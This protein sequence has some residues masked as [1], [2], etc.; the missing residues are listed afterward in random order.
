MYKVLFAIIAAATTAFAA[1]APAAAN[2]VDV[3][4]IHR[5]N[6]IH[7]RDGSRADMQTPPCWVKRSWGYDYSGKPYLKKTRVCA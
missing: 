2:S 5:S 4:F 3:R 6:V 1:L 7:V